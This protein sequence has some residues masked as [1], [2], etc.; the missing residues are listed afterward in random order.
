[1]WTTEHIFSYEFFLVNVACNVKICNNDKSF[2]WLAEEGEE[3]RNMI[4]VTP[5]VCCCTFRNVGWV[6]PSYLISIFCLLWPCTKYNAYIKLSELWKYE[7]IPIGC[8]M[9]IKAVRANHTHSISLHIYTHNFIFDMN[10]LVVLSF[11]TC[12]EMLKGRAIQ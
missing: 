5:L 6:D 12:H 7:W 8:K 1:M 11:Y 9:Y 4:V 10:F 2:F 3:K